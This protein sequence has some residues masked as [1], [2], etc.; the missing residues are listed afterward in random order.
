MFVCPYFNLCY[1][2]YYTNAIHA[3]NY[4]ICLSFS[5][6]VSS[7]PSNPGTYTSKTKNYLHYPD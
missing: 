3:L 2:L 1:G 5:S 6:N 7:Q 4:S